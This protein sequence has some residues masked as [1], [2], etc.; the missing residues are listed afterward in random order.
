VTRAPIS[1]RTADLVYRPELSAYSD[2]V[3]CV[4]YAAAMLAFGAAVGI[5]AARWMEWL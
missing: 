2:V 4:L 5:G 3:L 1:T